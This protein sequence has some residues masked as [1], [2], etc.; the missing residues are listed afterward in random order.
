MTIST[1]SRPDAR[2]STSRIAVLSLVAILLAGAAGAQVAGRSS[3]DRLLPR[4]NFDIE[5]HELSTVVERDIKIAYR[6]GIE[7]LKEGN[8]RDAASKFDFILEQIGDDPMIY[9]VAATAARCMRS[10]R[11]AAGHYESAIEFEPTNYEAHRFL[12]VSRLA[13]GDVEEATDILGRLE[14]QRLECEDAC[15]PELE[16]AYDGLRGAIELAQARSA[17]TGAT[18]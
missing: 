5:Q 10:F 13:L 18:K 8:C 9:Y 4:V 16:E 15:E 12:G 11:A 7:D 1:R 3:M 2:R 6:R 14:L 17:E